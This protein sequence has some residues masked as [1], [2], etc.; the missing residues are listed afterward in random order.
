MP[1]TLVK[2]LI[3]ALSPIRYVSDNDIIINVK[4]ARMSIY[5]IAMYV[6]K[7]SGINER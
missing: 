7:Y 5:S 6:S 4:H 3:G 1:I 2:L